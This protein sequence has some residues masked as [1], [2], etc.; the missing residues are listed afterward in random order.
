MTIDQTPR[1]VCLLAVLEGM[2]SNHKSGY[3]AEFSSP[4]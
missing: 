4:R 2:R 3:T 1:Q